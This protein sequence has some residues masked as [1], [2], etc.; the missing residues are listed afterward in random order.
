MLLK[1]QVSPEVLFNKISEEI[2]ILSFSQGYYFTLDEIGSRIWEMLLEESS[3][4][5]E[6]ATK[7]MDEYEVELEKCKGDVQEFIDDMVSKNLIIPVKQENPPE[8]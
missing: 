5:Y 8:K 2:V 4:V 3:S 6:L 7:L 1:Y